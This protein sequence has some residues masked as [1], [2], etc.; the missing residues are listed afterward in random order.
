MVMEVRMRLKGKDKFEMAKELA[1]ANTKGLT[2]NDFMVMRKKEFLKWWTD[3]CKF[4]EADE[5]VP[6][7]IPVRL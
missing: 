6:Y 4:S 2:V 5:K 3:Y 1:N 7:G